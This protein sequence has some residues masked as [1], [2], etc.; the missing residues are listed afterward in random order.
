MLDAAL[1][2]DPQLRTPLAALEGAR[3]PAP[4]WFLDAVSV[5]P[6]RSFVEVE[7]A[8]I[9]LLAWGR[10]GAPGLMFVHGG[11]AHADWWD[12]IAP[13]FAD[14]YRVAALSLSGMGRSDWRT[15][16][17]IDQYAREVAGCMTAAGLFEAELPPLL[18]G[19]SFGSRPLFV[20]AASAEVELA[21]AVVLDA[22][23]SAPGSP[24][25]S[26]PPAHPSQVYPDLP[27]ALARFRLMPP[28]PCDN[29]FL[30]DHI[31]RHSLK[32]A[33]SPAGGEGFTW[34]FDPFMLN[35]AAEGESGASA[36]K[37]ADASLRA[38]RCPIVFIKGAQSAIVRHANLA[39]T[40]SIAPAGTSFLTVPDAAHHLFLDR[41]LAVV[42][43][44]QGV[45]A[46]WK[47]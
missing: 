30:L 9:E 19:H 15:A 47:V 45:F 32:P 16:Y 37:Q 46:G 13:F 27:A 22:A 42:E 10:R 8:Q 26:L 28:Q 2:L 14:R 38:A 40:Q 44:L 36:R 31:A 4:Q 23:I 21:G 29:L 24:E 12:F 20:V 25:I 39:Y 41:P 35:R 7:G 11:R 6:E 1:Q 34:R 3:P 5:E 33:P 18:V 43:A 17:S